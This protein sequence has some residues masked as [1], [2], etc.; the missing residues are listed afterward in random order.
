MLRCTPRLISW[1]IQLG[2]HSKKQWM[3]N[4]IYNLLRRFWICYDAIWPYYHARCFPTSDE[5]RL[6]WVVGWFVVCYI[7][8]IFIFSKNMEDHDRHVRLVLEKLKGLGLYAQLEKCEFHQSKVEFLGYIISGDNI[9][10]DPCKVQ[11][12]IVG[13]FSFCSKCLMFSW[14]CQLLLMFHCPLFFNSDPSYSVD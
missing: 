2:V 8:E 10:M 13:Y 4:N 14:I 1:S 5:W 12:I 7:D 11:T 3:K 9:H 6:L